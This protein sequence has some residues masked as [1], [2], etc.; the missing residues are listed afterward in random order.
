MRFFASFIL[1]LLLTPFAGAAAAERAEI[2]IR[3]IHAP[4][5][6][7]FY[8]VM[9]T[10]GGSKPFAAMLDSGSTG[11]RVLPGLIGPDD[12]E[13]TG[14]HRE[15]EFGSGEVAKGFLAHAQSMTIGG[16]TVTTP[17]ELQLV[18]E[19]SCRG[20]LPHCAAEDGNID[21]FHWG[22]FKAMLGI[23][24]E[25]DELT[26]PLTAIGDG[27]WIVEL[28]RPWDIAPGKLIFN[29]TDS[30][31]AGYTQFDVANALSAVGGC[32]FVLSG[33]SDQGR[34]CGGVVLDRG[35]F[36]VAV[37]SHDKPRGFP[38]A[39]GTK[40]GLMVQNPAGEKTGAAFTVSGEQGSAFHFK[41]LPADTPLPQIVGVGP[42]FVFSALYDAKKMTLGLK[43]RTDNADAPDASGAPH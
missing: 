1:A 39:P 22:A 37:M 34:V 2:P 13:E 21:K 16:V 11:L 29:P 33:Q 38:W 26:N 31:S 27:R 20:S 40:M 43:P 36:A 14:R 15:A 10:V 41:Y 9:V 30:E 32:L 12:A 35:A 8:Y 18:H 19:V 42:F 7:I 3:Q 4:N 24:L 17:M 25:K 5:G 28:P 6:R 23:R